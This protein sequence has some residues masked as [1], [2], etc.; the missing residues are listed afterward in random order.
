MLSFAYFEY[1]ESPYVTEPRVKRSKFF[2]DADGL[3]IKELDR[4]TF[5]VRYNGKEVVF[6]LHQ[7]SQEP[8]KLFELGPDEVFVM[9]TFDESGY[10]FFLLFNKQSN[11][12]FWVLNEEELVPD[13]FETARADL[14]LGRR[15]GF[16]FWID[17]AHGGRK[18]LAAIRGANA[19][20]NNYYDGPFDQLA[21]NC[22]DETNIS[23]YLQLASPTLRGRI[24]KY[25]YYTDKQGGSS[26]VAVSP[27]YVYFSES[28]LIQFM[29]AVRAADDPR[30]MISR[31]RAPTTTVSY[32]TPYPT[33]YATPTAT[34]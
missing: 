19:I 2:T 31:R 27:Y 22:V 34:Q 10:Q 29:G 4:F 13:Q 33:P 6:N 11:Y 5:Q 9:R 21:D 20:V 3:L 8:P 28:D 12:L 26:R 14:V 18:V 24:D 30:Y 7:L 15:S 25:G 17:E 1:K 32:P 23:E 16:A